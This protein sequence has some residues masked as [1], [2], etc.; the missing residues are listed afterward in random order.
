MI[1]YKEDSESSGSG[2][3]DGELIVTGCQCVETD[4]VIA[5]DSKTQDAYCVEDQAEDE[6]NVTTTTKPPATCTDADNDTICDNEEFAKELRCYNSTMSDKNMKYSKIALYVGSVIAIISILVTI[7]M[8]IVH[9][10]WGHHR[11]IHLYEEIFIIV[12]F[13]CMSY[14]NFNYTDKQSTCKIIAILNH[15]FMCLIAAAF[16]FEAFFASSM[17]SGSATK[18]G[19][20]PAFLNYILPII[21][22]L[23]PTLAS[24]YFLKEY[25]GK[26]MMHCF[27]TSTND[28]LW[29]FVMPVWLLIF[30][31]SLKAQLACLG[32]DLTKETQDKNQCHWAK[33]SAKMLSPYSF[34]LFSIWLLILFAGEH[35]KMYLF[36]IA[37]IMAG[38]FGPFTFIVHTYCHMNSC[39]K[40][41]GRP[42]GSIYYICAPAK[43]VEVVKYRDEDPEKKK[44]EKEPEEDKPEEPR[45]DEGPKNEQ[46][47]Y[48][49]SEQNPKSPEPTRQHP[50]DYLPKENSPKNRV[51][52]GSETTGHAESSKFYNWLTDSGAKGTS[53]DYLFRPHA[54]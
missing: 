33:R 19:T 7:I 30:F 32:C 23:I 14:M 52:P 31:A 16:L 54:I 40:L 45:K 39:K 25:Y 22:A 28:M 26:S 38:I 47:N 29:G 46:N 48:E 6:E 53:N 12:L 17:V 8:N 43:T 3:G 15:F 42:S 11:I 5:I 34:F 36:F 13:I 49:P 1:Q 9:K 18:N 37:G 50:R 27:A 4:Q 35:Q 2:S 44:K 51:H 21:V 10:N 20:I 24:Y 41:G